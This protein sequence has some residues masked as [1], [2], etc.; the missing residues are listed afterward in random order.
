MKESGKVLKKGIVVAGVFGIIAFL[1]MAGSGNALPSHD[2]VWIDENNNGIFDAGEWNGTSIQDAINA[3]SDGDTIYVEAGIYT[4][5]IT[6]NKSINL[7]GEPGAIIKCLATPNTVKIQESTHTFEYVVLI[8]GGTY[9]AINNTY[10]GSGTINVNISGFEINGS[11]AGTAGHYFAGIFI[12]NVVGNISNNYIHDMY[13]PSGN[14]SG[15]QTFGILAYGN[16]DLTV[17][18]NTVK[19]FSR[20]GIVANGDAGT[21]PDPVITIKNNIVYGNGLEDATGWNAENGIQIGWGASGTVEGNEIHDCMVNSTGWAS[22]G[23]IVT[24]THDVIINDNTIINCD[25]PIG[26]EDATASWGSPYNVASIWDIT[27]TNN[28]LD[29]NIYGISIANNVTNVAILYN[30]IT[31]T[32]YDAIDVWNYGYGDPSPTNVTIHYNN[33]YNNGWGLWTDSNQIDTVNATLNYWGDAAG[34]YNATLNPSGSGDG[35]EGNVDFSPWLGYPWPTSPMTYHTNDNIEDAINAASDGD[36]IK[37]NPGLYKENIVINKPLKIVGDPAI[38]ANG[39]IGIKIEANNTFIENFTISNCSIGVL[40]HNASFMIQNVTM[41]NITVDNSIGAVGNGTIIDNVNKSWINNTRIYNASTF[42]IKLNSSTNIT[43]ENC[44]WSSN[45]NGLVI[46]YSHHNI[47]QNNEKCIDNGAYGVYLMVSRHNKLLNTDFIS[48]GLYGIYLSN[49]DYNS[50]ENC[51][52]KNNQRGILILGGSTE[53]IIRNNTLSNSQ[54]DINVISSPDNIFLNNTVASYPTTFD[55]NSYYGNFTIDGVDTAPADPVG[56]HN[57]GNYLNISSTTSGAWMNVLI[58]YN[59]SRIITSED[60]VFICKYNGSWYKDGWNGS[61]LLNTTA[62]IVGVNI[63][64]IDDPIFAPLEEDLT[65]PTTT[66]VI[67]EPNY[68]DGEHV[69]THTPIWLNATDDMSGVNATYYRIWYNNT[70]HPANETDYY[71]GNANITNISGTCWYVYRNA[72]VNFNPIYFT[73]ECH[74]KL[75]F[76]SIDNHSNAE[77]I[78]TQDHYVD[79]SPPNTQLNIGDPYHGNYVKLVTVMTLHATDGGSCAVG[80]TRIHYHIWNQ[81]TGWSAWQTG[82]WG[83]DVAFNFTK[84]CKH[85]VEYYAEDAL[86]NTEATKNVTLYVD[87]VPPTSSLSIVEGPHS[88]DYVNKNT[89]FKIEASDPDPCG[90]GSAAG[91]VK[92]YYRVWNEYD[93]WI[94]YNWSTPAPSPVEF[95]F[96]KNCTHYVEWYAVDDLGNVEALHNETF[97]CDDVAPSTTIE[98]GNPKYGN[99]VTSHTPIWLNATD[100]GCNNGSGVKE[101]HYVITWNGTSTEYIIHDNDWPYDIDN[102]TGNISTIVYFNEECNHTLEWWSIDYVDNIEEHH[103][104]YFLVDNTPPDVSVVFGNPVVIRGNA[105]FINNSTP[106]WLNAT[107]NGTGECIVGGAYISYSVIG[108]PEHGGSGENSTEIYAYNECSHNLSY[109]VR[110]E[111]GNYRI[112]WVN[113]FVDNSPPRGNVSVGEPSYVNESEATFITKDTPI[114]INATDEPFKEKLYGVPMVWPFAKISGTNLHWNIHNFFSYNLNISWQVA[115][116]S[117]A[118]ELNALTW[119]NVASLSWTIP[120]NHSFA[121]FNTHTVSVSLGS[122][123]AILIRYTVWFDNSSYIIARFIGE[124]II[125]QTSGEIE[126]VLVNFDAPYY[127]IIDANNFEIEFWNASGYP[128]STDD[129][130]DW[131]NG[132]GSPPIIRNTSYGVEIT[133]MDKENPIHVGDVV[134]FGVELNPLLDYNSFDN[135]S[136]NWTM[137]CSVESYKIYYRV[138]NETGLHDTGWLEGEWNNSVEFT[139]AS[140]GF[141]DNCTHYVEYYI[142]D[143]LGNNF[144]E[145]VTIEF[146]DDNVA[147]NISKQYGKPYYMNNTGAEY[148]TSNTPIYINASDNRSAPCV[149]GSVHVNVSV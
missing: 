62:N 148:I 96:T 119:E 20:G 132:W 36:T 125:N 53:N 146:K 109:M 115:N 9:S 1:V 49:A 76:Y 57:L 85:Y 7:I 17:Y 18:G 108:D 113:F 38:D 41:D 71:G 25:K 72:T 124:A 84:T 104:I 50:I 5:S 47:I 127:D 81:F 46:A 3:A 128:F 141:Y 78:T 80:V 48:G 120:V 139:M 2:P 79:D 59:E 32:T 110:D 88:G 122:N 28:T 74:H 107:D 40:V 133:W 136:A 103:S 27:I 69:T 129:I 19:D 64:S 65:P 131:F 97:Y 145:P 61:R 135:I 6:I 94:E 63:T 126:H 123:P 83:S 56:F 82:T 87:E 68:N 70:W 23:I 116:S 89:T 86:G 34:P 35:V 24:D 55:I 30:E 16:S 73:E 118:Y 100:S 45:Q 22:S 137:N 90:T 39:S 14:G 15:E 93:G 114:Y 26:V 29:K 98:I 105:T 138:W 58:H 143:D 67:G 134:H 147:P 4:E 140:R 144:T 92:I 8:A 33:I 106:I 95:N 60:N 101:L 111:L 77:A 43:I 51:N 44:N 10:Y 121:A 112:G 54:W 117:S 13:G 91:G 11:N 21:L 31:N 142:V 42:A 52:L 130:L 99:F 149:V 37:V 102:T 66:K 12:R 75:Q